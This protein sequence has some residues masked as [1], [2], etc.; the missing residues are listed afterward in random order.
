MS[1]VYEIARSSGVAAHVS[2][3][4]GPADLLLPL[5]DQGRALGID[6]T[7]DTYPY[8]AGSTILGM[9]ALPAWVQEG[10]IEATLDGWA[11]RRSA[12]G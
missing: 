5:M 8:L 2:H 6:L 11:T 4:N 12:P 3:Y 7:Y 1:E 9:V 10:G